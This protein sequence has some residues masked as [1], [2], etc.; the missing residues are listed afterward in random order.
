MGGGRGE[1]GV[2][3]EAEDV[4]LDERR[5][6]SDDGEFPVARGA[7]LL[8]RRGNTLVVTEL[9]KRRQKNTRVSLPLQGKARGQKKRRRTLLKSPRARIFGNRRSPPL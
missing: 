1:G 4:H 6:A 8:K 3:T 9:E 2:P 7:A 5:P